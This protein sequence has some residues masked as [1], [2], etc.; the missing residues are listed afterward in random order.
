[1][2]ADGIQ[3]IAPL[4]EPR[5]TW[6]DRVQA[7]IEVLLLAGILSSLIA[8]LP[9]AI[10]PSGRASLMANVRAM[11]VYLLLEASITFVLLFLIMRVHGETLKGLGLTWERWRFRVFL[12]LAIVPILFFLNAIISVVFQTLLPRYFLKRNPLTDLIRTPAD[13]ILFVGTALIAGGIKEE[14]QRAFILRRF[15]AYLGG[16]R[17]GLILW[18]VA[19]G[20]GHYVQGAQGMVAAGVYGLIFGIAYLVRRNLV[21]PMVAHGAYDTIALLGYWFFASRT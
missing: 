4:S 11:S 6:L 18:S 1:M 2:N 12:G 16:A 21:I 10:S 14:L 7:L 3:G 17:L 13:L 9:F 8:T 15:Q 20:L 5:R 19:F